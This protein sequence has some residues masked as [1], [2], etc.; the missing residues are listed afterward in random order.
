M[1]LSE[2]AD[3][4]FIVWGRPGRSNYTDLLICHCRTAGFEPRIERTPRQGTPPVT[5]VIG[6]DR[7]AFVTTPAG[8]AAGGA[9]RILALDPPLYAPLHALY[10][11]RTTSPARDASSPPQPVTPSSLRH[12]SDAITV[13]LAAH[14]QVHARRFS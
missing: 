1:A 5:A 4:N 2:L 11:P 8:A 13:F 10:S 7:L 3:Q 9:V 14:P 6:T 12:G